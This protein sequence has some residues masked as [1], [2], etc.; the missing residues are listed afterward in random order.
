MI[1]VVIMLA[2]PELSKSD[3]LRGPS[4]HL[5][6]QK[7]FRRNSGLH[8]QLRTRT[9]RRDEKGKSVARLV[10]PIREQQT[11][12]AT[13]QILTVNSSRSTCQAMPNAPSTGKAEPSPADSPALAPRSQPTFAQSLATLELQ[14]ITT[15][16]SM[17]K[18]WTCWSCLRHGFKNKSLCSKH[19]L[20]CFRWAV[21]QFSCFF[22]GLAGGIPSCAHYLCHTATKE[23]EV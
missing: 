16:S 17:A 11:Y 9:W 23:H 10:T 5:Y 18:L 2:R 1:Q 20:F 19:F 3:H 7:G 4:N 13:W 12:W 6:R 14:H 22:S 8:V 21:C 15:T